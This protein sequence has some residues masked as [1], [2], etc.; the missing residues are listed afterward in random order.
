MQSPGQKKVLHSWVL[1]RAGQAAPPLEAAVVTVRVW[2]C[3]PEP[4]D[5]LH[6]PK[7]PYADTTQSPGQ[8]KVLQACVLVRVG[9]TTPPLEAAVVTVRVWVCTPEPHDLLHDPKAPYADTTQ[10]TGQARVLQA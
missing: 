8:A 6:D 1:V 7:A 9:Q 3:T 2:V 10:F 4:H 5:L